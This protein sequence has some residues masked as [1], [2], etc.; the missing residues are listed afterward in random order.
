MVEDDKVRISALTT[1][2]SIMDSLGPELFWSPCIL[3]EIKEEEIATNRNTV[4]SHSGEKKNK[5]KIV[6]CS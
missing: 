6:Q 3:P 5:Q 4:D 2:L 1:C